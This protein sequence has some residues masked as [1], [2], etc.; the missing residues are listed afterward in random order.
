MRGVV[1]G[2]EVTHGGCGGTDG[3]RDL[4][5]A[6]PLDERLVTEDVVPVIDSLAAEKVEA[7]RD[8]LGRSILAGVSGEPQAPVSGQP[9]GID[10]LLGWVGASAPSMPSPISSSCRCSSTCST[11]SRA[12]A[13][14]SCR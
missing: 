9:V 2:I 14:V 3:E 5:V 8:V 10:E 13:G 12:S 7:R 4:L 1:L 11:I 6:A